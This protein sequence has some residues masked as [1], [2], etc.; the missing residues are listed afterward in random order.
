MEDAAGMQRS[1]FLT[2]HRS[3]YGILDLA[4]VARQTYTYGTTCRLSA[5]AG[6][7]NTAFPAAVFWTFGVTAE[8]HFRTHRFYTPA[9]PT[10]PPRLPATSPHATG[11]RGWHSPH[12][13]R[14][15]TARR[16]TLPMPALLHTTTRADDGTAVSAAWAPGLNLDRPRRPFYLRQPHSTS[17]EHAHCARRQAGS[18]QNSWIFAAFKRA[19]V[20]SSMAGRVLLNCRKRR[21]ASAFQRSNCAFCSAPLDTHLSPQHQFTRII[22][23]WSAFLHSPATLPPQPFPALPAGRHSPPALQTRA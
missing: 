17:P 12:L 5:S 3:A 10:C 7:K 22:R 4:A 11:G 14:L 1:D 8:R 20:A 18:L 16:R 13:R 19:L 15:P 2:A 21:T 23:L 6:L 9:F